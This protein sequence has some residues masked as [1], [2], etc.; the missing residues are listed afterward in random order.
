MTIELSKSL[1]A[2]AAIFSFFVLLFF[3]Y[4]F[5]DYL[6]RNKYRQAFAIIIFMYLFSFSLS[7]L[8]EELMI[9]SSFG[10]N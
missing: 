7:F 9:L 6:E 2:P 5:R 8:I 1:I 4:C 10:T 3:L